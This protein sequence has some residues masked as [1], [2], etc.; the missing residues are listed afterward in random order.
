MAFCA[1]L[2]VALPPLSFWLS[3]REGRWAGEPKL[4]SFKEWT[5]WMAGKSPP[6]ADINPDYSATANGVVFGLFPDRLTLRNETLV[7]KKT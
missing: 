3:F 2:S 1:L 5:L 4:S 7:G 6:V